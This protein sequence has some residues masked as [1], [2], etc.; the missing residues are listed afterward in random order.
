MDETTDY[1][2]IHE[3]SHTIVGDLASNDGFCE[4]LN[5]VLGITANQLANEEG[6]EPDDPLRRVIQEHAREIVWREIEGRNQHTLEISE[7][8]NAVASAN[9]SVEDEVIELTDNGNGIRKKQKP[10]GQD[11]GR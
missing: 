8:D 6:I 7:M 2:R 5:E 10:Q 1:K 11:F 9:D 4:T 3:M